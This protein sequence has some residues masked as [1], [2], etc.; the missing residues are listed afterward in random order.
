MGLNPGLDEH[1]LKVWLQTAT[2]PREVQ[3]GI[4]WFLEDRKDLQETVEI[5]DTEVT[6][7]ERRH[8]E[9]LKDLN[10]R[11]ARARTLYVEFKNSWKGTWPA[12]WSTKY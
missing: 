8:E 12:K 2:L 1:R 7:M 6:T 4:E 9:Q 10:A 11:L 5:F 3:E